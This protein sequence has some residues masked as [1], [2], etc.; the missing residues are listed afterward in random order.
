MAGIY[1]ITNKVNGKIY[2]GSTTDFC[3]RWNSHL[4]GLKKQ[5]HP[6]RH[7]QFAYNKYGEESFE[8]EILLEIKNIEQL[9][10]FEQIFLDKLLP[11]NDNGYNICRL[12]GNGGHLGVKRSN[13]T[14][15]KMSD[16]WKLTDGRKEFRQ[17]WNKMEWRKNQ[18]P[19]IKGK[20]NVEQLKGKNNGN[21]KSVF[22]Y[23][24][25]GNLIKEWEAIRHITLEYGWKQAAIR[26]NCNLI[27][28]KDG[29]VIAFKDYIWSWESIDDIETYKT[30]NHIMIR[31]KYKSD[32]YGSLKK[33][34]HNN[35]GI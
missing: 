33:L 8:F 16:S 34:K 27:K 19:W 7:L 3:G 5:K 22:Q 12:V 13:N 23:D 17:K 32:K 9:I 18:I 30:N 35:N 29:N 28:N 11:F 2:V 10:E 4:D 25:D 15:Q 31:T 20:T 26:E 24:W 6:N 14:K 1:K 21:H